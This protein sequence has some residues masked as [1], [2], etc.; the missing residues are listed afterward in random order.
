MITV[1]K[2]TED[3]GGLCE[4]SLYVVRLTPRFAAIMD[5]DPRADF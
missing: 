2:K 5:K 3:L 1:D 4:G